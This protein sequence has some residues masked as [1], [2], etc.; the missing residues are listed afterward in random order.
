MK[1][2]RKIA[3]SGILLALFL[4]AAWKVANWYFITTVPFT[5]LSSLPERGNH[6]LIEA[7]IDGVNRK[8]ALDTGASRSWLSSDITDGLNQRGLFPTDGTSAYKLSTVVGG[9]HGEEF[10]Y[11]DN[12]NMLG[13]AFGPIKCCLGRPYLNTHRLTIDFKTRMLTIDTRPYRRTYT[14]GQGALCLRLH[15]KFDREAVLLPLSQNEAV[16]FMLDTGSPN[17]ILATEQQAERWRRSDYCRSGV[18]AFLYKQPGHSLLGL[19]FLSRYKVTI[20][21]RDRMLYLE[22]PG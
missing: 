14:P 13:Y 6:I 1:T 12:T 19:S 8:C 18:R 15:P 20:D 4:L 2:R 22:P 17:V 3:F 21:Y 10:F 16:E 7:E 9:L 11:T 5:Y